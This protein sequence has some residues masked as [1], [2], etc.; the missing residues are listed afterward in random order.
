MTSKIDSTALFYYSKPECNNK[1]FNKK[2]YSEFE[3]DH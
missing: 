1:V 2:N 3:D